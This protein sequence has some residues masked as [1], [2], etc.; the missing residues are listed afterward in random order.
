MVVG[1][2]DWTAGLCLLPARATRAQS[3]A[4]DAFYRGKQVTIPVNFAPGGPTAVEAR[5]FTRSIARG[6]LSG[7]RYCFQSHG[8]RDTFAVVTGGTP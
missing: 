6:P 1:R 4:Q 3:F 5:L 7:N 8:N 2:I